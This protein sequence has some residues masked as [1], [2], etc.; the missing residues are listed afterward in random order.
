LWLFWLTP[1]FVLVVEPDFFCGG[2]CGEEE[3]VGLFLTAPFRDEPSAAGCFFAEPDLV[4]LEPLRGLPC[5]LALF[6]VLSGPALV[7]A[8]V[9]VSLYPPHP[10]T[11]RRKAA[12]R[13][14][15]AIRVRRG[16]LSIEGAS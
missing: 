7:V 14:Q 11:S 3:R 10:A 4:G 12:I 16:E 8:P 5:V 2:V 13:P 6:V 1:G 9:V 15:V